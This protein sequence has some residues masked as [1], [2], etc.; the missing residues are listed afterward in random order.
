[1]AYA[2]RLAS[3]QISWRINISEKTKGGLIPPR[4]LHDFPRCL[5]ECEP[6]QVVFQVPAD[7]EILSGLLYPLLAKC[8]DFIVMLIEKVMC[9]R[10]PDHTS[11]PP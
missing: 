9:V 2:N 6:R 11:V 5:L 3:G 10:V 4:L 1:M 7:L 8:F